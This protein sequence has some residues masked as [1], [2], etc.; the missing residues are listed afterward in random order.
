MLRNLSLILTRWRCYWWY[1]TLAILLVLDGVALLLK[2]H[3]C[4]VGMLLDLVLLLDA[5]E[6][7][8][9]AGAFCQLRL[10]CC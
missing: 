2:A 10:M 9:A 7:V 1:I 5:Q 3:V 8:V 4:N 6:T